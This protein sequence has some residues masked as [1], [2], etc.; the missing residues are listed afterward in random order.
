MCF[1][2]NGFFKPWQIVV[3]GEP[4]QLVASESVGG[5]WEILRIVH[6]GGV[7]ESHVVLALV[8]LSNR[9]AAGGAEQAG[10]R[11]VGVAGWFAL[12]PDPIFGQANGGEQGRT[13]C[14]AAIVAMT[15]DGKFRRKV[16]GE[17]YGPATAMSAVFAH[18]AFAFFIFILREVERLSF[19]AFFARFFLRSFNSS[20]IRNP[21][22]KPS[23][24]SSCFKG[25]VV[26][27][28]ANCST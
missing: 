25:A 23:S 7:D 21:I 22:C 3:Q 4:R 26:K 13:R 16:R 12:P 11:A 2:Q 6:E 17:R 10:G 20:K 8:F 27:V 15:V 28:R 5:G 24:S 1:D 18:G 19:F 14:A 9:G